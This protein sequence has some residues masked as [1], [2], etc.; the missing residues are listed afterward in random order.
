MRCDA[1]A[2]HNWLGIIHL[3]QSTFHLRFS[4]LSGIVGRMMTLSQYLEAKKI[5]QGQFAAMIGTHQGTVSKLCAGRR[6]GWDMAAKIAAITDG[7]VPVS[8]WAASCGGDE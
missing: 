2:R 6:P 8:V 3:Q 5:T 7:Q 1:A 4:C